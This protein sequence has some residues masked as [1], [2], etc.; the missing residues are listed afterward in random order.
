M[1]DIPTGKKKSGLARLF[2]VGPAPILV[3]VIYDSMVN[4]AQFTY[5]GKA[6]GY[7][8]VYAVCASDP[9]ISM[10]MCPIKPTEE[11]EALCKKMFSE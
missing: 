5:Y 10:V 3:N 9:T 8:P 7:A 2:H 4:P 6:S 11:V 1:Q